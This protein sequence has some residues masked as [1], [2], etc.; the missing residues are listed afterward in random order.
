MKLFVPKLH[1]KWLY[2]ITRVDWRSKET[3]QYTT[4]ENWIDK[5]FTLR[6]GCDLEI[7]NGGGGER[8]II[9]LYLK[10]A[11]TIKNKLWTNLPNHDKIYFYFHVSLHFFSRASVG[12]DVLSKCPVTS[13]YL[14][15]PNEIDLKITTLGAN[16]GEINHRGIAFWKLLSIHIKSTQ[17]NNNIS[18]TVWKV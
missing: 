12:L 3:K 5:V 13:L 8:L 11:L 15:P 16:S 17:L 4:F 2:Q 14:C 7:M 9:Y 18:D 10:L 6:C 1:K